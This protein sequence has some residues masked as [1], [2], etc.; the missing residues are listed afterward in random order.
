[1]SILPYGIADNSFYIEL[2]IDK[3]TEYQND[4]EDGNKE[5]K[6]LEDKQKKYISY[7]KNPDKL[8]E[9]KHEKIMNL[10]EEKI[11]QENKYLN[12][13]S[14]VNI[15]EDIIDLNLHRSFLVPII[16]DGSF[17]SKRKKFLKNT[18]KFAKIELN[19]IETKIN[20]IEIKINKYDIFR[21]KDEF[22]QKIDFY[23]DYY[24]NKFLKN[25][26]NIEHKNDILGILNKELSIFKHI[27][28]NLLH[29]NDYSN[30]FKII[31]EFFPNLKCN[32][33]DF[34]DLFFYFNLF[35]YLKINLYHRYD[36]IFKFLDQKFNDDIINLIFN[37]LREP[38]INCNVFKI[39]KDSNENNNGDSNRKIIFD[40]DLMFKNYEYDFDNLEFKID[41]LISS[42]FSNS[43]D[44]IK[45]RVKELIIFIVWINHFLCPFYN[46]KTILLDIKGKQNYF[47][48][49]KKVENIEIINI[50]N[51]DINENEILNLVGMENTKDSDD[52]DE[53]NDNKNN[54]LFNYGLDIS[55]DLIC[56]F[57]Y[58]IN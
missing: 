53:N 31:N 56:F 27:K 46:P 45:N 34:F 38:Y 52:D 29:I 12:K 1:M 39:D 32:E 28:L 18:E 50:F 4:I 25:K 47:D 13:E 35:Y 21:N 24:E 58:D 49:I 23:V 17:K 3:I 14:D 8:F 9:H 36:T 7:I 48:F 15:L 11:S 2:V 22:N 26:K 51:N 16:F 19:G 55:N 37:N 44:N 54:K 40:Y 42:Y 5:L 20:N 43:S 6:I 30:L 33:L 41:D 57:E 10:L